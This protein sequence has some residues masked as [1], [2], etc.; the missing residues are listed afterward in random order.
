MNG[1]ERGSRS[2][3]V[4]IEGRISAFASSASDERDFEK[5]V[6]FRRRRD[7]LRMASCLESWSAGRQSAFP[8]AEHKS[9][10]RLGYQLLVEK[11]RAVALAVAKFLIDVGL[12]VQ[13]CDRSTGDSSILFAMPS[14]LA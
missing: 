2:Q 3:P 7:P 4:K 8:C 13:K 5:F 9:V 1:L 10:A 11:S 6:A 14:R 12:I